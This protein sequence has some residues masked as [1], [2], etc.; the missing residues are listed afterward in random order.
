MDNVKIAE[1]LVK[2]AKEVQAGGDYFD[3][4]ETALKALEYVPVEYAWGNSGDKV[5][6][7]RKK[8]KQIVDMITEMIEDYPS[9]VTYIVVTGMSGEK[10]V[11]R[12]DTRE[13]LIKGLKKDGYAQN[14]DSGERGGR[15]KTLNNQ[16][17]FSGLLGPMYDG[18][19][20]VRYETQEVYN[21][22]SV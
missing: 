12:F 20:K 15:R 3:N 14:G 21:A 22:L 11:L 8:R 10:G 16:P 4:L 18:S 1:E 7:M 19:K 6:E 2:L 13:D 5:E 17:K 9:P